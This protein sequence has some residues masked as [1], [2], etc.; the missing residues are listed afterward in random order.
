MALPPL[1]SGAA[2][3]LQ[4]SFRMEHQPANCESSVLRS[5][6]ARWCTG[7]EMRKKTIEKIK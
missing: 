7:L 4:H 2:K 6:A 5:G 1:K 3:I